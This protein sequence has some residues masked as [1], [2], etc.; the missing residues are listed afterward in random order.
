MQ[1]DSF[2]SPATVLEP[3]ST[4]TYPDLVP[5]V[6]DLDGTLTPT[7]TLVESIVLLL[8]QRP[9]DLLRLPGWLLNG[10]AQLKD[11]VAARTQLP[12]AGLP[13]RAELI[14]Y[15]QAE[16]ARGRRIVLATAAHHD[17]ADLAAQ[18]LGLFDAV[19]SSDPE[20]NLKGAA[21]LEA[22]RELVGPDFIYV[23]DSAADLPIWKAANGAVLVGVSRQVARTVR[24]DRTPIEREFPR[25]PEGLSLWLRAL[26]VH[27]WLKNLLLFVPM[28]TAFSFMQPAKLLT[29]ACAFLAFSLVASATYVANDLWDLENDRAHP[30]KRHRPFASGALPLHHGVAVA[31]LALTSAFLL[32]STVSQGFT[33]VLLAYL[34]LTSSYSWALKGYVLL[35][36]LMLALL[37]TLRI[38]A[39]SVAIGVV[40]SSWLLAFSVFIFLSLA[41]VKRCSELLLLEQRGNVAARGRDYR[42]TDLTVLWPL[43]VGAA[44]SSIVVFG[45]FL[46]APETQ[47]RYASPQLLW[48]V[49]FGLIYWLGRLWI[50][51]ARGEMH[52]DPV[53]FAVKDRG[54]RLTVAAI[55]LTTLV[56]RFAQV[57][58]AT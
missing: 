55:V 7:D 40:T 23:G 35:D 39:G 18:H 52:D 12:V 25:A 49:A 45:L 32:A 9:Q 46:S 27:Q 48:L 17:I 50:K 19:L 38:V 26:R 15:L 58:I 34:V 51:T 47:A 6:V 21:K 14:E 56:A 33:L 41:L 36:V 37:Y 30:R 3:V 43:G 24:E 16:K 31:A 4:D 20:H 13:W 57:G 22:I 2:A 11:Q 53:L 54:S 8:K 1:L 5:L 42:V 29:M 10:R 28:L 44:L